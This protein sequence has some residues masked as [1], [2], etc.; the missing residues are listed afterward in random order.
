[1]SKEPTPLVYQRNINLNDDRMN[2]FENSGWKESRSGENVWFG[3]ELM[4][5]LGYKSWQTFKQLIDRAMVAA[6]VSGV[7]VDNHFTV[8][9]R[10]VS[11][12]YGNTRKVEDY[13]LSKY[14]CYLIAQNGNPKK[15]QIAQAQT[16]FAIQT[17]RQE[18]R[19]AEVSEIKRVEARKRLTATEKKF[20]GVLVEHGV[21]GSGLAEIRSRGDS[22]LFG[23]MS[24]QMMKDR[25]EVKTSAP[26][27]DYLPTVSLK[28]KDL[29]AE[30][31]TVNT[32]EKGLWGSNA[33]GAEH[34]SNNEVV[35]GALASRGIFPELLPAAEDIK[36]VERRLNN[37]SKS[38]NEP[39]TKLLSSRLTFEQGVDLILK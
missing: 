25:Y 30:M 13:T 5:L 10:M 36:M 27:A 24:T 22:V 18:I 33:I 11:I 17:Q 16:Y 2:T 35:R 1:M 23:G 39:A 37:I 14:A 28:A 26:L 38:L 3:R 21:T 34:I 4:V 19:D 12:G 29:A 6:K 15:P 8:H 7:I 32:D 20:S 9:H 31:T